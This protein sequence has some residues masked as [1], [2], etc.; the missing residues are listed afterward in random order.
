MPRTIPTSIARPDTTNK[1]ID[2]SIQFAGGVSIAPLRAPDLK[3][4]VGAA[5]AGSSASWELTLRFVPRREAVA[6]NQAFRH[7]AYA[8]NVLT[9]E[10]PD[11]C[12]ADILICPPVVREQAAAQRKR[13]A[14]HLAHMVVH[15]VLHALGHTHDKPRPASRM[16]ALE[17]Q[18]LTRFGI[19][20]PYA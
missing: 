2:L 17:R 15:G 13:Y 3:R 19:A 18:I 10:Y 12:T 9:F 11:A 1:R 7:A 4:L 14:H 16:E 20:D 8:P 5:T 6:M